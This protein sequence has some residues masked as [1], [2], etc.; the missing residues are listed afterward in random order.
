MDQSCCCSHMIFKT[1]RSHFIAFY[2]CDRVPYL[3]KFYPDCLI[4][5][6]VLRLLL[7]LTSPLII[8]ITIPKLTRFHSNHS[9]CQVS[10]KFLMILVFMYGQHFSMQRRIVSGK[11]N[12]RQFSGMCAFL[13]THLICISSTPVTCGCDGCLWAPSLLYWPVRSFWE[14]TRTIANGDYLWKAF[15]KQKGSEVSST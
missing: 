5:T 8:T 15:E 3:I 2:Y 10:E 9:V 14:H 13:D 12:L 4:S 1:K 6:I 7:T 11:T